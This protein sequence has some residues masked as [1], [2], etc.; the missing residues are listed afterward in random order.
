M[1]MPVIWKASLVEKEIRSSNKRCK[2]WMTI[3]SGGEIVRH[4]PVRVL[5]SGSSQ[6]NAHIH[7]N[8]CRI[9]HFVDLSTK[10]A[11][12]FLMAACQN[13]YRKK[14]PKISLITA[15]FVLFRSIPAFI[16]LG[17]PAQFCRYEFAHQPPHLP[18]HTERYNGSA[19][20]A[21]PI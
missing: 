6:T 14:H 2:T 8:L 16:I 5:F 9:T 15:I 4:F 12:G 3:C 10:W 21:T 11:R 13:S 20:V 7:V 17:V 19:S 1:S 18:S